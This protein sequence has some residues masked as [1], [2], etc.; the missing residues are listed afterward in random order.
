MRQQQESAAGSDATFGTGR[1]GIQEYRG[2]CLQGAAKGFV[3]DNARD[4]W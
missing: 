3:E 1:T 4:Y 2:I